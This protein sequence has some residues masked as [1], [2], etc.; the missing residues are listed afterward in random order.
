MKPNAE[1]AKLLDELTAESEA[2]MDEDLPEELSPNITV[3]RRGLH[4][5][6]PTHRAGGF[7]V[8]PSLNPDMVITD[9]LVAEHQDD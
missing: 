7:P 1:T 2:Y 6:S 3:T 4:V 9:E 8:L 5:A